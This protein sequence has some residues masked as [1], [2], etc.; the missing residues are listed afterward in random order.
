MKRFREVGCLGVETGCLG[1]MNQC[2]VARNPPGVGSLLAGGCGCPE[3]PVQLSAS[4]CDGRCPARLAPAAGNGERKLS[5]P[6]HHTGRLLS[7]CHC[8]DRN[9]K[10]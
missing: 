7:L 5:L 2:S 9:L 3:Q 8:R 6:R 1:A 4:P 10:V